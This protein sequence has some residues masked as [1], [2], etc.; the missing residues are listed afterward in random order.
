MAITEITQVIENIPAE[1]EIIVGEKNQPEN[2]QWFASADGMPLR[3]AQINTVVSQMNTAISQTNTDL[4]QYYGQVTQL[5]N[6][7]SATSST[8]STYVS[9]AD[10]YKD[11]ALSAK[12]GA[13]TAYNNTASLIDELDIT[14]TGGYTV[15]AV[16]D[17][18]SR[19]R[20]LQIVG[21]NLI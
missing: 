7:M 4:A 5:R 6:E 17:L 14:G 15:D 12:N 21:L 13:E 19:Q 3:S 10:G 18:M 16:D 2:I 9:V 11:E 1:R 20:N 8:L